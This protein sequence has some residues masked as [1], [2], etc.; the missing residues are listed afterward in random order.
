MLILNLKLWI[1]LYSI[2]SL[3]SV[4]FNYQVMD[5][6]ISVSCMEYAAAPDRNSFKW[7]TKED[8][9]PY[10]TSD[11]LCQ[12]DA[13]IP[14]NQRGYYSISSDDMSKIENKRQ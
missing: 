8:I 12:I 4:L 13:P 10:V 6:A 14:I 5:D 1:I 9:L 11:I 3:Y 2:L 7:P